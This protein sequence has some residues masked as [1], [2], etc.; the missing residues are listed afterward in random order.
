MSF[1][2]LLDKANAIKEKAKLVSSVL[3]K[4]DEALNIE[5]SEP[6]GKWTP[7]DAGGAPQEI[8]DILRKVYSDFRDKN[9]SEDEA[10][11]TKGAKIAWGAV[12]NAGWHKDKDGK[13][14]KKLKE[15]NDTF[16]KSLLTELLSDIDLTITKARDGLKG[17]IGSPAVRHFLQ[18]VKAKV[19]NMIVK[20]ED[21][22]I[23][24]LAE[25][26]V[27]KIEE[28]LNDGSFRDIEDRIRAALKVSGF[29]PE[30]VN[31]QFANGPYIRDMYPDRCV[32]SYEGKLYE[33]SYAL[34]DTTVVLGAP[35]EVIETYVPVSEAAKDRPVKEAKF[36]ITDIRESNVTRD[37]EISGF[38]SLKEAKFNAD[39]SEV[40]VVLIEAGVNEQKKRYYPDK[41]IQEAAGI[42]KGWKNYIDHPTPTQ[43]R[44]RPERSLKDWASTIVESKYENGMAIGK[45]AIHDQWLR[46]RLAD[47]V[48]RAQ[49]GLSVLSGGRISHG[50]VNGKDG[51]EIVEAIL[52]FRK[53]G[54]PS[55]DWVTEAGARGRVSKLLESRY[56]GGRKM[57]LEN[58]TLKEL[59]ESRQDLVDTI[60]REANAGNTEKVTKLE[61]D[62][63]EANDKIADFDKVQKL[64]KQAETVETIL[65]EAKIPEPCKD[66]IRT[67]VKDTII[68]GDLKESVGKM[69]ATELEFAN[70]LTS[71]GK[72]KLGGEGEATTLKESLQ[73]TLDKRAGVEEKKEDKEAKEK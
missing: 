48:A 25:S 47:P 23:K 43:E 60:V 34:M 62:L 24:V 29:F 39:F 35:R 55:V 66:R 38:I 27:T 56:R 12:H 19:K 52:P 36:E 3:D 59:K 71:K 72:I 13:W 68:E 69:I 7:P 4:V 63:K 41:T 18:E 58:A 1:Q 64:A 33:L 21:K 46:E 49:L 8:K 9:P 37:F 40:E 11:K 16:S 50:K 31:D 15:A 22:E 10:T 70:K 14:V 17:R 30:K 65:K 42:F 45:I 20:I 6:Q 53:S 2:K 67:Q 26:I 54:P 73:A 51:Y 61:K 57:E 44:E 5:L 28:A 32:V